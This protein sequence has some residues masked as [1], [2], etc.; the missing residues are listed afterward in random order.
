MIEDVKGYFIPDDALNEERGNLVWKDGKY[1]YLIAG[2]LTERRVNQDGRNNKIVSE[3]KY[4]YK[5]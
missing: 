5:K 1:L 2:G 4:Y 3:M